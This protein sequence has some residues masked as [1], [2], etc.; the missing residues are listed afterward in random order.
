MARIALEAVVLANEELVRLRQEVASL[1]NASAYAGDEDNDNNGGWRMRISLALAMA[2]FVQPNLLL[3]DEPTNHLDLRT[4]LWLEEYLCRWKKTRTVEILMI[5]KSFL[6]RHVTPSPFF[7]HFT[8]VLE[9][10]SMTKLRCPT[11]G[12]AEQGNLARAE[13]LAAAYGVKK[14]KELGIDNL[15]IEGDSRTVMN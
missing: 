2:L 5:L 8:T 9:S 15:V 7:S 14:A 6:K 3:L 1:Q 10:P 11:P 12:P 13:P 4:V